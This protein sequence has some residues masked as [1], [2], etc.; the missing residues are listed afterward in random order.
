[1]TANARWRAD[2]AATRCEISMQDASLSVDADVSAGG[3]PGQATPHDL[4]DA[5]L[6][7]CTALT[8]SLYARHKGFV[9]EGVDVKVHHQKED[10]RYVLLREITLPPGLPEAARAGLLRVADACPIH[11]LL[12][13]QIAIRTQAQ[14][15]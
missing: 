12:S 10:D 2:E 9:L 11:K 13:G 14:T 8:M 1:M 3:S 4:L 6:A 7:S 5:A 15:R